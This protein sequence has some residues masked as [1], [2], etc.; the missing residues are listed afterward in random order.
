MFKKMKQKDYKLQMLE[1]E[2]QQ[3]QRIKEMLNNA[4]L[5]IDI[6]DLYVWTIDNTCYIVRET[7]TP[8]TIRKNI[9]VELIN[10]GFKSTLIDIFTNE[11]IYCKESRDLIKREEVM[12]TGNKG[13]CVPI[14]EK[15]ALS[16]FPN[17]KVPLYILKHLYYKLNNIDISDVKTKG[18]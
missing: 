13:T 16:N 6:N 5:E 10:S 18:K 15:C 11:I 3:L 17:K 8:C 1:K 14:I 4:S 7:V 2:K 9:G 12:Y